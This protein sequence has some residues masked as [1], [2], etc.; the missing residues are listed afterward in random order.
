MKK[1]ISLFLSVLAITLFIFV[2]VYAAELDLFYDEVGLLTEDQYL[3]LN[4]LAMD[5]TEK[6]E[7]EVIIVV[8]EDREDNEINEYAKYVYDE[9]DYGYGDDKSGL[10]L[11]ISM[12]ERDFAIITYGS[13]NATFTDYG[14]KVLTEENLLPLLSEDKYYEG[15]LLYLNKSAEFLS[16]AENGTPFDIDTDESL[17]E[18]NEKNSFWLKLVATIVFPLL[19]AGLICFIL[20]KQMKSAIPERAAK[21]YICNEGINFTVQSDKFLYETETRTTMEDNSSSGGTSVDSDSFSSNKGK[22]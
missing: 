8:V 4:N 21:C 22:F 19:I 14:K 13:A 9:Y 3:E 11:F 10:M 18:D 17:V 20:L 5:I 6:Y 15:F 16:M 12:K 2:P 1:I 7:C